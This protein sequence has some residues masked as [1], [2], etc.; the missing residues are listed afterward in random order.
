[1]TD[2]KPRLT[3]SLDDVVFVEASPHQRLLSWRLGAASWAGPLSIDQYVERETIL[4]QTAQ[5]RDGNCKYWVLHRRGAPEDIISSC[6]S[7]LK[8]AL[9]ADADGVREAQGYGIASVFTNPV[10]R[11]QGMAGF[12]L[13]ELQAFMDKTSECSVLYSDIGR[14]YYANLGW[15]VYPS[16]QATFTLE[17]ASGYKEPQG[18]RYLSQDEVELLCAK[19][20]DAVAKEFANLGKDG[21]THVTFLPSFAQVDNHFTKEDFIA[22]TL[23]RP[24]VRRRGA[25]TE[26]GKAWVYWYHDLRAKDLKIQRIACAD[27]EDKARD[28]GRLLGA[29][30]AEAEEWGLQKISVW[31][32]KDYD[33]AAILAVVDSSAG[34]VRVA[35]EERMDSSVCSF[36]WKDGQ[37]RTTI[38]DNN[39]YYAWC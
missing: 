25:I 31:N 18:V 33:K 11:G 22:K 34:G 10:Y 19:D 6:E 38:W 28:I 5:L 24:E 1:M 26:D 36:R 13:R 16:S 3:V 32:S 7:A 12:M 21:T 9:I 23:M 27:S 37:E 14:T 2:A 29:A 39:E 17:A 8:P 35:F 30:L 15:T 4:S 20:S